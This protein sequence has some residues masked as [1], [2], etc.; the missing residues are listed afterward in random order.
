M[1]NKI[2][3][4]GAALSVVAVL[5]FFYP[6][7]QEVALGLKLQIAA[8][9]WF[10]VVASV[11]FCGNLVA[12]TSKVKKSDASWKHYAIANG[13]IALCFALTISA[14]QTGHLLTA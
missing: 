12:I 9:L 5:L 3:Y 10:L 13:I 7:M 2:P 1:K 8:M 6:L 14:V 11:L 4:I